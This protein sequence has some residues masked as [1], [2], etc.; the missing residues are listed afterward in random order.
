MTNRNLLTLT[1]VA[2]VL[3]LG[4]YVANTRSTPNRVPRLNGQVVLPEL[5]VSAVTSIAFGDT[6]KL[7]AGENGWTVPTYHN[8]PADR[9]K[10]AEALLKLADLKVGQVIRGKSLDGAKELVLSGADGRELAKLALGEKHAKWGHGRYA[11]FK[12][13]TVLVSET[14]DAFEGDGKS[15]VDT[16]IVES[17]YITFND[18]V[19]GLSAEELG[20]TTGV[21]AKVTIG[22]DTNRTVTVGGV[23][24]GGSDRYLKL[25][26]GEW[27]YTVPSY[28]VESLLPKPPAEAVEVESQQ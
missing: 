26:R 21:V 27:V 12:G 28:A 9:A 15:F 22:G 10:L 1:A 25:D 24:K 4:A 3:G 2:V 23:V 8:Y 6:L 18:I 19:E 5:D 11:G 14:L 7:A 13:E 17:P 20:F 16:K